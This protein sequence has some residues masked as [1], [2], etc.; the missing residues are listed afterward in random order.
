M[1]SGCWLTGPAAA[2][3]NL[4]IFAVGSRSNSDGS[5]FL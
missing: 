2:A 5:S 3:L 1:P 4:G